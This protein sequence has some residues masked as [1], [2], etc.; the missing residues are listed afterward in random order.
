[1]NGKFALLLVVSAIALSGCG[2]GS[3]TPPGPIS[4][5]FSPTPP[6]ALAMGGTTPITAV[7]S[8]DS[9]NKGVSWSC[10]PA[11]TCGTFNPTSTASN[12][13]T[14]YT[15]PAA[16]PTGGKVM[17]AATS[18]S[19]STKNVSGQ[20]HVTGIQISFTTAPPSVVAQGSTASP[21]AAVTN[22][23]ANAGVSWSC[24]PAGS[25]GSFNP[26]T[27]PSGT[28]TTYTPPSNGANVTITASS[29]TD[30]A[31][32]VSGAVI[33]PGSA[34]NSTLKGQ[35]AFLIRANVGNQATRGNTTF[36]GSVTLD[37]AGN[38]TAGVEEVIA[39]QY[40][41]DR[42]DPIVPTVPASIPNTSYYSVDANGHAYMRIYTKTFAEI[43]DISLVVTSASHAEVIESD[44]E[45]GFGT[46]D[47]QTPAT[48]GFNVSQV[49][50]TYAFTLDGVNT[51]I[52]ATHKLSQGGVFTADGKGNI[53]GGTFDIND[54][55]TASL[56]AA[57]TSGTVNTPPD[58]NG[59]G[60]MVFSSLTPTRVFTF[61]IVNNRVLRMF[62]DDGVDF[63]GGSAYL[64]T[65]AA[66]PQAGKFVYEH[67]GWSSAGRTVGAG[68]FTVATGGNITTGV[69]DS[70]AGGAPTV[71]AT[72]KAVS[73]SY[74]PAVASGTLT[75]TDAAGASAFHV[76]PVDPT[77][78]ILDPNNASGGGGA[79]LL[80]T[81]AG[82][83]GTGVLLPQNLAASP[84]IVASNA[85]NLE[86]AVDS[87]TPREVALVGVFTSDGVSNFTNGVSDYDAD[88][89]GTASTTPM[90][91]APFTGTY[92]ADATFAGHFTGTFNIPTPASGYPFIIPSTNI[93]AVSLYQASGSQAFVVQTDTTANSV[94]RIIQQ[95][96]P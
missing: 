14:T 78:N 63:T 33:V 65:S 58:T 15:A 91:K 19:D 56:G 69:S 9:A 96:L 48:G 77:L 55:G 25:C 66:P 79:L 37:G 3:S 73:G 51:S 72:G 44:G 8:N 36:I 42:A 28:A 26:T 49:S 21:V 50:G 90:L 74:M 46:F 31:S 17:I 4:V 32:S 54:N 80:H 84:N 82:I 45:P 83:I 22:D 85:V 7:V 68:Q 18:V 64:Q 13:P 81:D 41:G 43:L 20:I 60:Q 12:A 24:T 10:T 34:S 94:G 62:E 53:T 5:A 35:Y 93:F 39:T 29:V 38:I 30:P 70:N 27:T 92:A 40:Q 1:M 71:A 76:Y 47:L 89:Q 6:T 61:Y 88:D 75:L 86:N 16:V 59:R 11:N 2:G 57:I 95:Q 52:P 23:A 87:A 67:S